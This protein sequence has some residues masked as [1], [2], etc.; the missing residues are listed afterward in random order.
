MGRTR[1]SRS[2]R[3][4]RSTTDRA[5]LLAFLLAPPFAAALCLFLMSVFV[6]RADSVP[7]PPGRRLVILGDSLTASFGLDPSEGYP[8]LLQKMVD[9][10]ELP[11]RVVNAGVSGDT[12]SGGIRR[13]DWV[14]KQPVDVF[15][16]ALGGNDGLRGI[17][18]SLTRSNLLGILE[19]VSARYPRATLVV[20]GMQM[21]PNMGADYTRTFRELFPEVARKTSATLIPFL[22][23]GVGGL[24]EMNQP[25]LIHPTAEG[26][27]RIAKTVWT[28]VRPLLSAGSSV[29]P[30]PGREVPG[31]GP[32]PPP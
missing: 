3:L 30:A 10:A 17:P 1:A 2:C 4:T 11:Y 7:S 20:A 16:L 12:T 15:I 29:Q 14:L 22:L 27:A 25:D 23:E 31:R 32:T 19:K 26:H 6:A 5:G 21:P 18:P 8:A 9:S 28:V 24:P 13:V